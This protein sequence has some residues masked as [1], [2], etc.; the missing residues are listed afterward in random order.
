[1]LLCDAKWERLLPDM[2]QCNVLFGLKPRINTRKRKF[3]V[4]KSS[5]INKI[6]SHIVIVKCLVSSPRQ[7]E[8][9]EYVVLLP[10]LTLILY[11]PKNP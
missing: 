9:V 7:R 10:Y 8:K 6:M 5:F 1:M 11:S 4:K 2:T 3:P